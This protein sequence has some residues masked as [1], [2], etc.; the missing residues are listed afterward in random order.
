MQ[1]GTGGREDGEGHVSDGRKDPSSGSPP[2]NPSQR[3]GGIWPAYHAGVED[4]APSPNQQ[5]GGAQVMYPNPL[6]ISI[7]TDTMKQATGELIAGLKRQRSD[8][9]NPQPQVSWSYMI[10]GIPS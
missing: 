9:N 1:L 4:A 8:E 5:S 10:G 7:Y 2:E 6:T 3:G